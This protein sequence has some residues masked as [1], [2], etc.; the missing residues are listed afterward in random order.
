MKKLALVAG[1]AFVA[2]VLVIAAI[3][4]RSDLP[5]SNDPGEVLARR[6]EVPTPE[7]TALER[8]ENDELR[9]DALVADARPIIDEPH[10]AVV[11]SRDASKPPTT[12]GTLVLRVA[13]PSRSGPLRWFDARLA[14]ETRFARERCNGAAGELALTL[15]PGTYATWISS[16]GYEPVEIESIEVA[17]GDSARPAA[18][19]LQPGTGVIRA[20]IVGEPNPDRTFTLELVGAGRHPCERCSERDDAAR[21]DN[22][23]A[24]DNSAARDN[25]VA[26]DAAVRREDPDETIARAWSRSAPCSHCGFAAARSSRWI[27]SGEEF[28]FSHLASGEYA[29]RLL[30]DRGQTI[31]ATRRVALAPRGSSSMVFDATSD[32]ELEIELFD[33]DGSSLSE[34]WRRRMDGKPDVEISSPRSVIEAEGVRVTVFDDGLELANAT[35]VPP[36][37]SGRRRSAPSSFSG[38]RLGTGARPRGPGELA[39]HAR[40]PNESLQPIAEKLELPDTRIEFE[41]QSNGLVTIGRVPPSALRV[42]VTAPHS[43]GWADV[44]A[45]RATTHVVIHMNP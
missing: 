45:S 1:I 28:E 38:R 8:D 18:I 19:V 9:S 32:R 35:L 42:R 23:T 11:E 37:A 5:R 26:R 39:D 24:R 3:V 29:L 20:R 27:R 13:D 10:R 7:A 15:T 41:L 33:V 44:P 6:L 16:P 21:R 40:R 31:G 34:E 30:D 4:A 36:D 43:Y 2:I 14:S 22:A 17:G 25:G 12:L